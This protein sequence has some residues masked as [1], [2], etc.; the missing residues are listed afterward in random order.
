MKTVLSEGWVKRDGLENFIP[1]DAAANGFTASTGAAWTWSAYQVLI[2]STSADFIP[3]AIHI[4][5]RGLPQSAAVNFAT[6]E[7]EVATGAAM[8]EVLYSRHTGA[9]VA[10]TTNALISTGFTLPMGPTVIPSGTQVSARIRISLPNT[11]LIVN[12]GSYIAGYDQFSPVAYAPYQLSPY[13]NGVNAAQTLSTP[14]G[15]TLSI[16]PGARP[17]YG[18]W[19]PVIASAPADLLVWGA[20]SYTI[21]AADRSLVLEMGTGPG[22]SEIT[23]SRI[24]FPA[25]AIIMNATAQ[26][27]RRP[28]FVKKGEQWLARASGIA[29][30]ANFQFFYEEL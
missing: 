5:V 16:T 24:G 26:S 23:R 21:T 12:I 28:M 14:S 20:S 11:A 27:L 9:L 13:L 7:Y 29:Q 17:A 25:G 10:F 15:S 18:T 6:W 30:R 4:T 2:A 19:V 1:R 22:G 3:H 8:S